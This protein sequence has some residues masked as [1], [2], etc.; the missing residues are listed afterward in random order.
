MRARSFSKSITSMPDEKSAQR[1]LN[2]NAKKLQR[3]L[4]SKQE[5]PKRSPRGPKRQEER[6]PKSALKNAPR[7]QQGVPRMLSIARWSKLLSQ[8]ASFFPNGISSQLIVYREH[9]CVFP[10]N[11]C[12]HAPHIRKTTPE[13][14]PSRSKKALK[15]AQERLLKP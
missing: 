6:Q 3:R 10:K 14:P 8:N 9:E 4:K 1:P 5:R 13:A 15:A 7:S 2:N 11:V 12:S